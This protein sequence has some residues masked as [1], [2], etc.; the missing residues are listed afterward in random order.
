[1]MNIRLI[2]NEADY[3]IAL[4]RAEGLM[5]AGLGTP[6]GDELDVLTLLIENYEQKHHAIEAPD[7]IEFLKNTMEFRG[8]GQN[9]LASILSSRSRASEILNRRRPLTLDQIRKISD[10]WQVPA[11]PLIQKYSC[12]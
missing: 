3:D 2:H 8:M 5:N 11:D 10:A 7:P 4:S 1:M 12:K 6:E 9:S